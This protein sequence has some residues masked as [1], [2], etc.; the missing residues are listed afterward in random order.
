MGRTALSPAVPVI[1]R[2]GDTV[3]TAPVCAPR[4]MLGRTAGGCGVPTPAAD[5]VSARMASASARMATEGRTARQV[6]G[7]CGGS[8]T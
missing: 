7:A 4:A 1:A 5:E 6:A 2:E 8:Q 3:T